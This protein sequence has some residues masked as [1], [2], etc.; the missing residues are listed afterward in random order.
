MDEALG[1]DMDPAVGVGSVARGSIVHSYIVGVGREC[2][3]LLALLSERGERV[4]CVA[5][6]GEFWGGICFSGLVEFGEDCLSDWA[7]A[8]DS[9][10]MRVVGQA[11][12]VYAGEH[13]DAFCERWLEKAA[14]DAVLDAVGG[15]RLAKREEMRENGVGETQV[16]GSKGPSVGLVAVGEC[17][18][19]REDTPDDGVVEDRDVVAD[20]QEAF[21]ARLVVGAC[22]QQVDEAVETRALGG[23]E[24]MQGGPADG[25]DAEEDSM[26]ASAPEGAGGLS[27]LIQIVVEVVYQHHEG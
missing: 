3:S 4:D 25:V 8:W 24:G 23:V 13:A 19:Q 21:V 10:A 18:G 17:E 26:R 7:V 16:M 22:F 27:V 20:G 11:I 6:P 9:G 1:E 15:Q 14:I 5:W 2:W 12:A